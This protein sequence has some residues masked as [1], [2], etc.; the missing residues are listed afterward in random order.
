MSWLDHEIEN[1]SKNKKYSGTP[2]EWKGQEC[3][4]KVAKPFFTNYI[5]SV[6]NSHR[7]AGPR[8]TTLEEDRKLFV[9]FS[10][11]LCLWC[12]IQGMRTYNFFDWVSNTAY[13]FYPSWLATSCEWPPSLAAFNSFIEGF[14]CITN[15]DLWTHMSHIHVLFTICDIEHY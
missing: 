2:L 9:D 4:I 12:E 10:S 5:Y 1:L 7:S 13:L 15:F 3:L 6:G 14:Q 11:I 8:P